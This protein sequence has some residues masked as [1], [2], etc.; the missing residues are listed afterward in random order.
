MAPGCDLLRIFSN[1]EAAFFLVSAPLP[2]APGV[3]AVGGTPAEK[4]WFH[5]S[6][7]DVVLRVLDGLFRRG[8]VGYCWLTCDQGLP[9]TP[10]AAG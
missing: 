6:A 7:P 4:R 9:L 8:G 10:E 3:R 1:A 5:L 2:V